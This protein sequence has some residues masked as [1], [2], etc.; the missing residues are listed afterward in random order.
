MFPYQAEAVVSFSPSN[1]PVLSLFVPWA[2]SHAFPCIPVLNKQYFNKP[3][4]DM[5]SGQCSPLSREAPSPYVLYLPLPTTNSLLPLSVSWRQQREI[6]A[7]CI[8][9]DHVHCSQ[10]CPFS[11]SPDLTIYQTLFF[12]RQESFFPTV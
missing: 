1:N 6:K 11:W 4:E 3:A 8:S 2:N 7:L 9:E 5:Q 10:G 12:L